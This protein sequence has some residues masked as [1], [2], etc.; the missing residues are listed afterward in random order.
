MAKK[1]AKPIKESVK[2]LLALRSGGEC[3]NPSC[4]NKLT[5]DY[6]NVVLGEICHIEAASEGGPRYNEHQDPEERRGYD[7][8]IMLC[9]KCHKEIDHN[10]EQYPVEKL[11]KWKKDH[12]EKIINLCNN[13]TKVFSFFVPDG[14]LPRDKEA[15]ILFEKIITN[16]FFNLIGVGGSGKSS[17]AYLMMQKHES[18]FNEIAYVAVNNFSI[19]ED[20]VSQLN[21]YLHIAFGKDENPYQKIVSYME[22]NFKTSKPNLLVLDI[23]ELSDDVKEFAINMHKQC[24]KEWKVLIL[25]RENIDTF[26]ILEKEDINLNQDIVFLKELF[27]KRAGVRYTHFADFDTLFSVLFYNPLLTEQLGF[28]LSRTPETKTIEQIKEILLGNKFKSKDMKGFAVQ[29]NDRRS[30]IV[31]FLINLIAYD[32]DSFDHNEKELLRHFVLW[33][34]DYINYKVIRQLLNGVFESVEDSDETLGK[35]SDRAILMTQNTADGSLS[36]KLHGLLAESLREQIHLSMDNY[37]VYKQNAKKILLSNILCAAGVSV[38]TSYYLWGKNESDNVKGQYMQVIS[39]AMLSLIMND[40]QTALSYYNKSLE[41]ESKL[42]LN[43]QIYQKFLAMTYMAYAMFNYFRFNNFKFTKQY[44]IKAI[45][46]FKLLPKDDFE[47]QNGLTTAYCYL[48]LHSNN[49]KESI[50]YCNY[51]IEILKHL[52]K[53]N[54]DYQNT[55][56]FAYIIMATCQSDDNNVKEAT[57]NCNKAI[58]ILKLLPIDD[59]ECQKNYGFALYILANL[60]STYYNEFETAKDNLNTAIN[61]G[62]ELPTD[63][64]EYQLLLFSSYTSLACLLQND[65]FRDYKRAKDYYEEAI[66]IG[67][68]FPKTYCTYQESLAN[69][70]MYFADFLANSMHNNESAKC[71]HIKEIEIREKLPKD[72]PDYLISL[73]NAYDSFAQ[74]L[75]NCFNDNV[76]AKDYYKKAIE[77]MELLPNKDI[78]FKN[79]LVT[80]CSTLA[81]LLQSQLQE[82]ELSIDYYKK[83]IYYC[84]ELSSIDCCYLQS[85]ASAYHNIGLMLHT[86]CNDCISANDYYKKAI[87]YLEQLPTDNLKNQSDLANCYNCYANLLQNDVFK[88]FLSAQEYYKKAILIGKKLSE[89][90]SKQYL[91]DYL[92]YQTNSA[93]LYITNNQTESS[94]RILNH[95]K[96]QLEKYIADNSVNEWIT[97]LYNRINILF[98]KVINQTQV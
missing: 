68:S 94:Q 82:Y 27:L 28:Y 58:T 75:V 55:L 67:A 45:E 63:N 62:L 71:Q 23:N 51:A 17:L 8:L 3:A 73:A 21:Q 15:D 97:G 53:D 57:I 83:V 91:L 29:T 6:S 20:I 92:L 93:E 32:S 69:T 66:K 95:V 49:T 39:Y 30:T 46:S 11:K 22:N 76:S 61:I 47:A 74:F 89:K 85:L 80:E 36:Y 77:T 4:H 96:P 72:N 41:M 60:Q 81:F 13:K 7:N 54:S 65:Y 18:D 84:D 33:Q 50:E 37:P 44:Y 16:R 87:F 26:E 88:D 12:E 70:Y 86:K 90:N 42:P 56:A 24:P 38:C 2:I 48:A 1:Q 98:D 34:T 59:P 5:S 64:P 14:L 52:P 10:A 78:E 31:N 35:L 43:H 40:Y 9:E 19:K 79:I 25:S